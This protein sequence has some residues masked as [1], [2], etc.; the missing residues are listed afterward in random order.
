M[1]KPLELFVVK[2]DYDREKILNNF[3]A[4]LERQGNKVERGNNEE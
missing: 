2:H 1:K 4:Y 3:I